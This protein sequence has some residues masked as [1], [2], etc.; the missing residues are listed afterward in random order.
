M[1]TDRWKF[2]AVGVDDMYYKMERAFIDAYGANVTVDL[3]VI[4]TVQWA[5][6]E[7]DCQRSINTTDESMRLLWDRQTMTSTFLSAKSTCQGQDSCCL[8]QQY[9][10]SLL[11][12]GASTDSSGSRCDE[13]AWRDKDHDLV[14][15]EC[16]VLVDDFDTTYGNSCV[17]YCAQVAGRECSGAWEEVG[18]TCQ[19]ESTQSCQHWGAGQTS[20]AI[21]ECNG[22]LINATQ[23]LAEK[24]NVDAVQTCI[25]DVTT[26]SKWYG[27]CSDAKDDCTAYPNVAPACCATCTAITPWWCG[28]RCVLFGGRCLTE[29]HLCNV[30]S[31]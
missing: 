18:D 13:A 8:V 9:F 4:D 2:P 1:G 5:G 17:N 28:G 3:F 19:V 16:T 27:S 7:E 24:A 31:C 30:C 21:C 25:D 11:G 14:C 10:S 6:L 22:P 23:A 29:I 15:G 20:D 12:R 26:V